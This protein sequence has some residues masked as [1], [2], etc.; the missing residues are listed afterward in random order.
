MAGIAFPAGFASDEL[1]GRSY[2]LPEAYSTGFS[3]YVFVLGILTSVAGHL[4]ANRLFIARF[5]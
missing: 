3:Y 2:L 5:R 1:G 4:V